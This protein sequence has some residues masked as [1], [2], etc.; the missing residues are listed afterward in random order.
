MCRCV[1][2]HRRAAAGAGKGAARANAGDA[3][4]MTFAAHAWSAPRRTLLICV[5]LMGW[6][7]VVYR[8]TF[9]VYFINEDF[10]WLRLC[11]CG[12]GRGLWTLLTHDVMGG[13]YSWRPLL[14]LFFAL[15]QAAWGLDPLGF[16]VA[17]VAWHG[18]AICVLFAIG[19]RVAGPTRAAV[20]ALVFATHPLLVESMSW[21]CAAG[22]LMAT[23]LALL[24][25][26][27]YLRWRQADGAAVWV[28]LPFALALATQEST[29]VV[30]LLL[31]S[32]DLFLPGVARSGRRR[33]GLYGVLLAVVLAFIAVRRCSS[34][35]RF[36]F[37]MVG[38][39]PQY[40]LTA[41][42]LL[43][44]L[45]GKVRASAGLLLTMPPSTAT[46]GM[47]AVVGALALRRWWRGRPLALWALIWIGLAVAPYS[48]LLLGPFARY[49]PLPLAGFALLFAEL[50]LALYRSM[51]RWSRPVAGA[52]AAALLVLWVALMVHKIDAVQARFVRRGELTRQLLL[53]LLRAVPDPRPG[54]TLAFYRLGDLRIRDA[55]FVYGLDDA[56]RLFY[57]DDSLQVDFRPLGQPTTDDAYHLWYH[58][59]RLE[60]FAPERK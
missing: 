6:M 34:P 12:P 47:V 44:F 8:A 51:T 15:N 55:V 42:G 13:L 16:R 19:V 32:V 30:P 1:A 20:A 33:A 45:A 58:D 37:A 39:D 21:T 10:T 7:L 54:S 52:C 31:L 57:G 28:V 46:A 3:R 60:R 9:A 22:G 48:L 29:V 17:T 56:V 23:A 40:P 25:V 11:R 14:Q 2:A 43:L 5:A 50:L 36:N 26:L 41:M 38:L 24:A 35:A 49:M 27:A 4:P 18:V 53:D 59:G